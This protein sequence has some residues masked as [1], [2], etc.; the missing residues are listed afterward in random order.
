M[1]I[2]GAPVS[3]AEPEAAVE[4]AAIEPDIAGPK[5]ATRGRRG[6]RPR[7]T[8]DADGHASL[9]PFASAAYVG[10]T[11]ADPFGNVADIFDLLEQSEAADDTVA[12]RPHEQAIAETGNIERARNGAN[13]ADSSVTSSDVSEPLAAPVVQPVVIGQSETTGEKKRGW[14]RR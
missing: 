1:E 10:P 2:V 4:A 6:R 7:R 13:D 5:R 11:P 12:A 14:W 8:D 3:A 9:Q